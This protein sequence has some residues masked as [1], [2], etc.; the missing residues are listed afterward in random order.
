MHISEQI[1]RK[2]DAIFPEVSA[3][4]RVLHQNPELSFCEE[5]TSELVRKS[6][7]N[8]GLEVLS[9]YAKHG[10][11]GVLKGNKPGGIIALRADMDA[12]PIEEKT[13][14]PYS[15]TVKGIMHACGH[16]A[17]T[18]ILLGVANILS[19]MKEMFSG[20][21]LFIFQPA[22]E[23]YPGG[24]LPMMQEGI[25]EEYSPDIIIG[26]HV[27]PSLETGEF[28][29]KPGIA[30]ASADEVHLVIKGRGGHAAMPHEQQDPVTAAAQ[31]ITGLQQIISRN[32]PPLIPSVLSFGKFIANGATNVIPD[33]VTI[34]GT[35]RTV[36][37]I[38]REKARGLI[39]RIACNMAVA[40]GCTC[41]IEINKGYP[42]LINHE[43]YT[44][45]AIEFSK[46]IIP[47]NKIIATDLRMTAEDFAYYA[48]R[49]PAVF[50][51][52]GTKGKKNQY[53]GQLHT[54]TFEIDENALKTATNMMCY[55]ALRFLEYFKKTV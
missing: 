48:Q 14:L 22:E 12:L 38:W 44:Q 34:S 53:T 39:G 46:E 40:L 1:R 52:F 26:H 9:G 24:A 2:A 30:M 4:F 55:Q 27:M 33:E 15:S 35:F 8:Y 36:D 41:E 16:D 42:S 49:Y 3:T 51:R 54:S 19:N 13:G 11:L 31:I 50:Y 21:V 5:K 6:L 43:E 7:K 28:G 32:A 29:F 23:R 47:D 25:F 45:K 17:H 37:E 18:S 10:I 20:T